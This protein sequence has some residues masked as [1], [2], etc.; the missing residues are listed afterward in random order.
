M[1]LML[2]CSLP[3][4]TC[5]TASTPVAAALML[6]GVDPGS[7]LVFLLAG[8]A[9]N[10]ASLSMLAGMMGRKIIAIYLLSIAAVS[11]LSGMVLNCL[12]DFFN[13]DIMVMSGSSQEIL[14]DQFG[15]ISGVVLVI[16]YVISLFSFRGHT[17]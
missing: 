13:F 15:F 1:L 9:T 14:P 7:A 8:P 6:K 16:L 11:V 10:M 3:V 12:Y 5:A 4:Y 17:N 2:L